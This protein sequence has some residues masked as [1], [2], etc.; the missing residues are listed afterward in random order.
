MHLPI[1]TDS[2]GLEADY[3]SYY[4]F[5]SNSPGFS[6]HILP[7]LN[8]AQSHNLFPPNLFYTRAS[9]CLRDWIFSTAHGICL[10]WKMH[11]SNVVGRLAA[12]GCR[13]GPR[14]G[15]SMAATASASE[16]SYFYHS[17]L[18]DGSCAFVF[19]VIFTLV[20]CSIKKR[21]N[22]DWKM[23]NEYFLKAIENDSGL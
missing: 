8:E 12:R 6:S 7:H 14:L 13:W 16:G 18:K 15:G 17:G 5:W 9:S 23:I 1:Q 10:L 19:W 21:G 20:T 4:F 3:Q 22:P 2:T 11:C